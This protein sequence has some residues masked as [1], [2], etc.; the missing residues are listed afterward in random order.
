MPSDPTPLP[1]SSVSNERGKEG[2]FKRGVLGRLLQVTMHVARCRKDALN[3]SGGGGGGKVLL[4]HLGKVWPL[5]LLGMPPCKQLDIEVLLIGFRKVRLK[6]VKRRR[7]RVATTSFLILPPPTS[8]DRLTLRF[9]VSGSGGSGR[10]ADSGTPGLGGAGIGSLLPPAA[11]SAT[12]GA[13]AEA[14]ANDF[15]WLINVLA[16]R[17]VVGARRCAHFARSLRLL[18]WRRR[19]FLE[20]RSALSHVALRFAMRD[21]ESDEV[22]TRYM[23]VSISRTQI[24]GKGL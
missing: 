19:A 8:E 5:R 24:G 3:A 20:L 4:D 11:P 22:P 15:F 16:G 12:S 2:V 14:L 13:F 18:R 10:G 1:S 9:L 17:R 6:L 23:H 7:Q 21:N